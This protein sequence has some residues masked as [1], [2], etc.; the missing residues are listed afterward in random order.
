M[1]MDMNRFT[2]RY[3]NIM[4][5]VYIILGPVF[6]LTGGAVALISRN[7]SAV[8]FCLVFAIIFLGMG[9]YH[10]LWQIEVN[11]NEI[12]LRTLFRRKVFTFGDIRRAEESKSGR[13]VS[14][15]FLYSETD[16]LLFSLSED[17]TGYELFI[18]CLK[19]RTGI[20]VK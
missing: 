16:K 9:I 1:D 8:F 18:E 19:Q 3:I 12:K 17:C 13:R 14:I 20:E 10:T 5:R 2:I 15:L 7:M 11:G 6:L 4:R